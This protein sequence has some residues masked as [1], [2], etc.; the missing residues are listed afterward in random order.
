MTSTVARRTGSPCIARHR[1]K[2]RDSSRRDF[3]V[4]LMA[5]ES[6]E[7]AMR[8]EFFGAKADIFAPGDRIAIV[9]FEL[10]FW[11]ELIIVEC[12]EA[13]A[14]VRTVPLI[15][16]IDLSERIASAPGF[17]TSKIQ[18][19]KLDGSL[20]RLKH[21]TRIIAS[22][23]KS[24]KQAADRLAEIKQGRKAS[25]PASDGCGVTFPPERAVAHSV[26]VPSQSPRSPD[27]RREV[28]ERYLADL[29]EQQQ[30]RSKGNPTNGR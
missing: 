7:D 4:H 27:H 5:D 1:L 19:E 10:A 2:E 18:I 25:R 8:P 11:A 20:Y 16:P 15:G 12:D 26:S 22:G 9:G 23:F 30:K 28:A 24:E 3:E 6:F 13:L 17:D 21:G 29:V 14:A